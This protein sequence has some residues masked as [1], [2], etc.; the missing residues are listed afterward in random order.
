VDTQEF[1][2]LA[3]ATSD[4][5]VMVLIRYRVTAKASG[6]EA[7]MQIHHYWRF[8]DGSVDQWRGSEDTEQTA[9]L[10]A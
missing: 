3:F 6:R 1:T 10:L 9:A 4:T 5:E 8:R 2:P 7:S